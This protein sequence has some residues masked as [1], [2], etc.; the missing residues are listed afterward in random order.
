MKTDSLITGLAEGLTPVRRGHAV[1]VLALALVCG[2][3]VSALLLLSWMG[4]RPDFPAAL[5]TGPFWM[6]FAYTLALSAIGLWMVERL[7][8]PG[9]RAG[10]QAALL[11]LP[12]AA[13]L[14]LAL[15]QWNVPGVDRHHLLMG[16]SSNVCVR[17]ILAIST[18]VF[19]ALFWA[20]RRLAP[21]RLTLAGAGAGL[22]SGALG[23]WIYAFAC[24]ENTAPF[25][26]LWYTLGILAMTV[27][28]A[29]LGRWV[30]RW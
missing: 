14:A 4:R 15:W 21:T 2:G 12:F 27:I 30:L 6:K 8:R 26:A 11:A 18:P 22:L 10:R 19:I 29:A 1:R 28:G 7:A 3:A 17:N 16:G 25:V 24:T 20:L 9:V 5:A 13:L 23:A